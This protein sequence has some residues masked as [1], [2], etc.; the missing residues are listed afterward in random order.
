MA[1]D[2]QFNNSTSVVTKADLVRA[3]IVQAKAGIM[4][5]DN[6]QSKKDYVVAWAV[7]TLGMKKT[8]AKVCVDNNWDKA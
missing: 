4:F 5:G 7:D 1:T 3:C 6:I 2:V 8:Q